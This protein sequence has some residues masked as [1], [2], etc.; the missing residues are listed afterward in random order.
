MGKKDKGLP[1]PEGGKPKVEELEMLSPP[2]PLDG[3]TADRLH[4]RLHQ[5]QEWFNHYREPSNAYHGKKHPIPPARKVP[6]LET[7]RKLSLQRLQNLILQMRSLRH[8]W[9]YLVCLFE[10]NWNSGKSQDERHGLLYYGYLILDGAYLSDEMLEARNDTLHKQRMRVLMRETGKFIM[11]L[12]LDPHTLQQG[13]H[14]DEIEEVDDEAGDDG[15][16]V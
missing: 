2:Y 16:P 11:H 1:P 10:E 8:G 5:L 9:D 4:Q 13:G 14:E 15:D 12:N 3:D 6:D 7:H